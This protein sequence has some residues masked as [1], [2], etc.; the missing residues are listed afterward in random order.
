M[1]KLLLV[2]GHNLL[3]QMF[4]GM[5]TRI[6]NR[7]GK[8]IHG[9]LGFIGVLLKIINT[10]T[11][12]YIVVLFDGEHENAR[13]KINSEYKKNRIDYSDVAEAE[14]PFSQLKY[15][16]EALNFIGI[17]FYEEDEFEVDD[18]IASYVYQYENRTNIV[19]S[20]FDSDYFQLIGDNVSVLRYR[21]KNTQILDKN[22]IYEKFGIFP[23]FYADFKSLTGDSADNI[24]GIEKI[25]V[26]T[27]AALVGQFGGIE[28]IIANSD[29]I[30]KER[31]RSSIKRNIQRLRDNYSLIK[32]SNV[33]KIPFTL[34]A[35]VYSDRGLTT[36]TILRG[37]GLLD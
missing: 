14:N 20:S 16:Y 37:I 28:S 32:L 12:S 18:I 3:F 34:D 19:I 10:V 24:K 13:F 33:N 31:V 4:Y 30:G 1:D 35:L 23:E 21:G 6:I 36:N 9:V 26:K 8:A 15:I 17:K 25:G 7:Q 5:P 27:A 22:A 29:E 11:P 2:D